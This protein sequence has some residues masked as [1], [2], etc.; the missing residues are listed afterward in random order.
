MTPNETIAEIVRL[1]DHCNDRQLSLVLRMV[2]VILKQEESARHRRAA[3]VGR[4]SLFL[5]ECFCCGLYAAG[6]GASCLFPSASAVSALVRHVS[7]AHRAFSLRGVVCI[8]SCLRAALTGFQQW[9]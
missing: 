8:V 2:Q 6:G 3:Q 4:P 7:K 9:S 1:L 5:S